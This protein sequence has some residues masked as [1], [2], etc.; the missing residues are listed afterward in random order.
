MRKS[1]VKSSIQ[2]VDK[3][4]NL[5]EEIEIDNYH[6]REIG[7]LLISSINCKSTKLYLIFNDGS[8]LRIKS[9]YISPLNIFKRLK[10]NRI[11]G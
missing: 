5:I 8:K 4:N 6:M 10:I 9:H 3:K 1:R 7:D 11:G 2:L